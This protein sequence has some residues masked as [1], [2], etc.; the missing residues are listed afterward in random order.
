MSAQ[1]QSE[2]CVWLIKWHLTHMREAL[3]YA[4]L[5]NARGKS[6][7]KNSRFS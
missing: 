6:L 4:A 3:Q 7:A 2:R 1:R 5:E